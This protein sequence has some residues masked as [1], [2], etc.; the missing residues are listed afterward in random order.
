MTQDQA[1]DYYYSSRLHRVEQAMQKCVDHLSELGIP[2][3]SHGFALEA[4]HQQIDQIKAIAVMLR[5]E[6]VS[7]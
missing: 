5:M 1:L 7:P 6:M 2:T 4:L 3:E